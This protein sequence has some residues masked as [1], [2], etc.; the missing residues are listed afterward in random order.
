[1]YMKNGDCSQISKRGW[2]TFTKTA[3]EWGK[4]NLPRTHEYYMFTRVYYRGISNLTELS[5]KKN[6]TK[7]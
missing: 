6:T 2:N 3:E 4:I 5:G 1:M 7:K